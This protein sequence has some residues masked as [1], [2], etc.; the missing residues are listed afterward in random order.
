MKP[1]D[2]AL[3]LRKS[4]RL[5][6]REPMRL[7]RR[8]LREP[9]RVLDAIEHSSLRESSKQ[10]ARRQYLVAV[11]AGFESFWREFIRINVDAHRVPNST[12]GALRGISFTI[13][14]IKTVLGRKLSLGELVSCSYS[15]QGP[16][17]VNA[18]LS[19]ILQCK[20][21][22]EFSTARFIIREVSRRRLPK[23]RPLVMSEIGGT[24][25]LKSTLKYIKKAYEVRHD[26]VHNT[27]TIHRVGDREVRTIANAAWQFCTF[28]GM[29]LEGKV[30]N[31]W[32]RRSP[33]V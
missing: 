4:A 31:T 20:V 2:K 33:Q 22:S 6:A 16:D 9:E 23:R 13:G 12:L 8:R 18:S 26:S 21:F 5:K 19:E 30:D 3:V 10:E 24:D 14:D 25:V 15:F 29:H 17:A 7:F 28:L 1:V 27:G 32:R 11:C